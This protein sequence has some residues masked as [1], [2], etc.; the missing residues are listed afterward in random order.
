MHS[1]VKQYSDFIQSYWPLLSFAFVTAFWGNFGQSFFFAWY[2]ESIKTSLELSASLYGLLYTL[3]T[4]ASGVML[5]LVG[6]WLNRAPLFQFA[7]LSSLGLMVGCM[8]LAFSPNAWVLLFALFLI[9]FCGQGLMPFTALTTMTQYFEKDRGKALSIAITGIPLGEILLPIIAV[10]L[11]SMF[12]WR[13]S[14][15]IFS[16]TI[17]LMYLPVIRRL[18]T[19][20]H[21]QT[22][23]TDQKLAPVT[24][25][26]SLSNPLKG[27]RADSN[28]LSDTFQKWS[29]KAILK[30]KNF[31]M[32]LPAI[33]CGPFVVTGVF[34]HQDYLLQEKGWSPAW[35]AT[36]FIGYG[37]THWLG[38]MSSGLL[39][40]QYSAKRV[41][42]YFLA[43]LVVGCVVLS[44][45]DS[46]L[47][48]LVFMLLIGFSIGASQ[49]IL[50]AFWAETYGIE[51]V[52]TVRALVSALTVFS[53]ALSPFFAGIL[54]DLEISIAWIFTLLFAL[55]GFSMKMSW[56]AYEDHEGPLFNDKV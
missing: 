45:W 54:V 38:T 39:V 47:V 14:W 56:S 28:A 18:L 5:F 31:L 36:C 48:A 46:A 41:I 17:P 1:I 6:G 26:F 27:Y 44:L 32:L 29:K 37:I 20:A 52:A 49:P 19:R 51:A 30:D 22:Y 55:S 13:V 4:L 33:L 42:H 53:T 10:W 25:S 8:A 16:L 15:W 12:D 43:P 23:Q 11:L 34:I 7:T 2:G 3:A 21:S 9:R 50:S 40:D 24:F 35:F